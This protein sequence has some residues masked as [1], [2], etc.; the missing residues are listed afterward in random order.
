[1]KKWQIFSKLNYSSWNVKVC[2]GS[3]F[4]GKLQHSMRITIYQTSSDIKNSQQVHKSH[5]T[6]QSEQIKS[7]ALTDISI[8]QSKLCTRQ[9]IRKQQPSLTA[10]RTPTICCVC[11]QSVY[12]QSSCLF[13]WRCEDFITPVWVQCAVTCPYKTYLTLRSVC[14]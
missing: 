10:A 14:V 3:W 11:V 5:F 12:V 8:R 4:C 2:L 6:A 1:M 7:E 13:L 9:E